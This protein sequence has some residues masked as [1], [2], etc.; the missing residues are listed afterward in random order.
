MRRGGR[1]ARS[2]RG[3]VRGHGPVRSGPAADARHWVDAEAPLKMVMELLRDGA[4]ELAVTEAGNTIGRITSAEVL[5]RLVDPRAR[6][7]APSA[8]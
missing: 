3:G 2:G 4:T 1:P 7:D 5:A 6:P 8:A